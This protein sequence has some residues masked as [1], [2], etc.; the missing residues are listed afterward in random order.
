MVLSRGRVVGRARDES[1]V[2][3]VGLGSVHSF[4][5]VYSGQTSPTET[6]LSEASKD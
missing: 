5:A 3:D 4:T 1:R 2:G 6:G